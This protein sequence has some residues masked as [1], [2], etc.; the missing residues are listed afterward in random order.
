MLN[1][2]NPL[3][4]NTIYIIVIFGGASL[5]FVNYYLTKY[6]GIKEYKKKN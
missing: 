5:L 6:I 4:K 3:T 2:R 1:L